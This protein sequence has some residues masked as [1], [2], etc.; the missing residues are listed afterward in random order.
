MSTKDYKVIQGWSEEKIKK[1]IEEVKS[2]L[3]ALPPFDIE[4][5][6]KRWAM[7]NEQFKKLEIDFQ[8][9]DKGKSGY[10]SKQ[11]LIVPEDVDDF[12]SWFLSH[13]Y[14]TMQDEC[15]VITENDF[16]EFHLWKEPKLQEK[17]NSIANNKKS[18]KPNALLVACTILFA[19]KAAILKRS[20]N[21]DNQPARL[22]A[23]C[24]TLGIKN[25][26][27]R[28]KNYLNT[29]DDRHLKTSIRE[30]EVNIFPL[31]SKD[32]ISRIK[33]EMIKLKQPK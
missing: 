30:I 9:V 3:Q 5:F 28:A 21:Y 20:K 26:P 10:F 19:E 29:M 1:G 33:A 32:H 31:L 4:L 18:K 8:K 7:I 6:R 27:K 12:F 23:G 17:I 13:K 22:D 14:H 16:I 11:G 25:A 15:P 2:F 24:K